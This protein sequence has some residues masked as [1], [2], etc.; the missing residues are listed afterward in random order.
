MANRSGALCLYPR[1]K[2]VSQRDPGRPAGV[3]ESSARVCMCKM[4]A[5]GGNGELRKENGEL[6]ME[7]G[8]GR[9][10]KGEGRRENGEW[11]MEN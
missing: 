2:M 4:S 9:R 10:E 1:I 3:G 8:E 6:R 5:G 11:R 7:K